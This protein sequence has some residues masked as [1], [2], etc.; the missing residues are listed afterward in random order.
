MRKMDKIA[1]AAAA[2]GMGAGAAA[3]NTNMLLANGFVMIG[4]ILVA[5]RG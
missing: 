2:I 4:L 5:T 1:I 3:G